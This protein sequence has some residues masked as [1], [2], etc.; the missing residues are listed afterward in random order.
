M[1]QVLIYDTTLRDGSQGEN[2]SFSSDEML[3]IAKK[4]DRI[5]VHYIEGGWP[6]SNA[7][8]ARFFDLARRESFT[9]ARITAFGATRKPHTDAAQDPN[10]RALID[11]QAPPWPSWANPGPCTWSRSWKHP[12]GKPGHDPRQRGPAQSMRA[13]GALRR[14][15]LFRRVQG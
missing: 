3:S 2:I 15:A 7:R 5:G 1:E 14:R 11:S 4:L 13:R 8:D 10:L 6:G 9:Q 12:R